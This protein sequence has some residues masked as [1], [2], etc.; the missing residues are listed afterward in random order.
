MSTHS[1]LVVDDER[2]IAAM[3]EQVLTD[4]GFAPRSVFSGKDAIEAVLAD[5]PD[6][7]LLDVS[8][9]GMDGFAVAQMLK[10]DPASA[11]IPI[12]MVTAQVGRGAK[13]IGLES[14]AE[15]YLTKPVDTTELLLKIRN[16]LRLQR[17]TVRAAQ[18]DAGSTSA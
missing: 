4:A 13:M 8:M 7:V 10:A 9:P 11:T 6:L 18:S 1:I 17:R 15:D 3:L 12:I 16:I 2:D 5:P 14:G